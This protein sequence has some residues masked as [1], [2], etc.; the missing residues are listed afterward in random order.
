M[1]PR[2]GLRGRPRVNYARRQQYQRISR[3]AEAA[4]LAVGLGVLGLGAASIGARLLAAGLLV[5][6]VGLVLYARHWFSLAGRSRVGARSEDAVQHALAPL[7][8]EAGGCGTRFDGPVGV[9]STRSRSRRLAS[10]LPSRQRREV[11]T[12]ATW[13]G[14]ISRLDGCRVAEGGGHAMVRSP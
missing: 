1:V 10:Q 7:E 8:A 9:T 4:L 12:A 5:G 11:T 13:R 14:S 2:E 3:A 6:A